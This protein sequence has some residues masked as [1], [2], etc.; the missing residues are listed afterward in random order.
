LFK[1]ILIRVFS[2][3]IFCSS[4]CAAEQGI[5]KNKIKLGTS[6]AL[7]GPTAELGKQLNYGASLYFEQLNKQGG[8]HG[9]AVVL[10][11]LDDGYEP[12]N[13]VQNTRKLIQTEQVFALFGYVGTPTSHAILPLIA[14]KKIPYIMPFTGADF[15]RTPVNDNIFNL[16]ASYIEE[17]QAQIDFLVTKQGLS[18]FALVIQADEF[19]LAGQR[20]Y[21]QALK[22]HNLTPTVTERFKRNS[23]NIHKVL[24]SI[25]SQPIDAVIF[26]GTYE[27]FSRLI[28]QGYEQGV[29]PYYGSLSFVSSQDVF[30]RLKYPSKVVISEVMPDPR[31]CAWKI[32][33]Q[34]MQ[35]MNKEEQQRVSRIQLEGYI[36]AFIISQVMKQCGEQLTRQCLLT[37]FDTFTYADNDLKINFSPQQH[38]GLSSVYLSFSAEN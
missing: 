18:R 21:E 2:Y 32:C 15:L 38:Q 11:S 30:S 24:A 9:R 34:L 35:G 27:P 29:N 4:L 31:R 23:S 6:N 36:N 14:Q 17:A 25:K 1:S 20:G 12:E 7:S 10:I 33:Q 26:V 8:I 13:T 3:L 5:F 22:Q 16:R 37:T 28:N 19:G